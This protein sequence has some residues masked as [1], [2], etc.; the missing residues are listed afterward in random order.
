[1]I[2]GPTR[3]QELSMNFVVAYFLCRPVYLIRNV[4]LIC[5]LYYTM[6][7]ERERRDAWLAKREIEK[8]ERERERRER[9]REHEGTKAAI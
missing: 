4:V 1:M 9:E 2:N 5:T 8:E 3:L 7:R 6:E